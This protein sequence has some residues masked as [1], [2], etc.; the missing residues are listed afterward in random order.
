MGIVFSTW[1]GVGKEDFELDYHQ[2]RATSCD[3]ANNYIFNF[4]V[5]TKGYTE[6]M[7]DDPEPKPDPKPEP[8][9]CPIVDFEAYTEQLGGDWKMSAYGLPGHHL[10]GQSR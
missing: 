8:E 10:E 4:R 1:D 9:P 5:R 2:T 3:D 6:D 7:P